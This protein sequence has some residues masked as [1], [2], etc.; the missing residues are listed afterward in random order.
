MAARFCRT[1]QTVF[2]V[3]AG[4]TFGHFLLGASGTASAAEIIVESVK[5]EQAGAAINRYGLTKEGYQR[6]LRTLPGVRQVVPVRTMPHQAVRGERMLNIELVGTTAELTTLDNLNVSQGRFLTNKDIKNRD[7]VA[8]IGTLTARR[9]FAMDNPVGK[10][11]RIGDHY[12]LV[13]GQLEEPEQSAPRG[14]RTEC[15]YIPLTTMQIRYGDN[16]I[17]RSAGTFEAVQYELSQIRIVPEDAG[18]ILP[19]MTALRTLLEETHKRQDYSI[20]RV[21]A[22][23]K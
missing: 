5:P 23:F 19:M 8:V 22:P 7:N 1:A 12:F 9:L 4:F 20:R 14:E 17:N 18:D 3:L 16:V 13:V 6:I 15:V 10:N 21:D 2:V 11:I